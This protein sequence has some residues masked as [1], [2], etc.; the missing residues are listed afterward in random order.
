MG[1]SVFSL[2]ITLM[3]I[4]GRR[5]LHLINIIKLEVW[6]ICHCLVLGHEAVMRCISFYILMAIIFAKS[7]T[8][9]DKQV[10]WQ[11]HVGAK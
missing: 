6:P 8:T 11:L 1:L 4:V 3:M 9:L 10:K 5:V 2:L 7:N